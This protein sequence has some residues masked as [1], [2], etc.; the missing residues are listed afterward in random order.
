MDKIKLLERVDLALN[1][2]RPH[3]RVDGGDIEVVEITDDLVL[4]VKWLGNCQSCSMSVMTMRAG[5]EEVLKQK[6]P[7]I[8]SVFAINGLAS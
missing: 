6:T 3:L 5:I 4:K 8:R 2:I 1:D 7:E